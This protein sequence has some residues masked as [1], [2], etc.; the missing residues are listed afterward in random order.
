M[1][2]NFKIIRHHNSDNLHLK[3]VGKLDGGA[4][5]ELVNVILENTAWFKRIF[6]HTCGLSSISTFGHLVFIKNIKVSR[7]RPH[8]LKITGDLTDRMRRAMILTGS[9]MCIN[10]GHFF[11]S[12]RSRVTGIT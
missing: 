6:V 11:Y 5:M 9:T 10:S 12:G 2:S 8:Q 1:A 4:A 7:L 3:P